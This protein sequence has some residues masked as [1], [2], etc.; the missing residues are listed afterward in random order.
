MKVADID[1]ARLALLNAG[2]TETRTLT[3][4]F[5]V[6]FLALLK[7]AFPEIGEA[8]ADR[9]EAARGEGISRRMVLLGQIMAERFADDGA[10]ALVAHPSDTVR[11]WACFLVGA[12]SD[13]S[14]AWRLEAVRPFA[15]DPHFGV[16]EWAW[17]AVR[18]HIAKDL[19]AAVALL[20]GWTASPSDRLRRFASEATRPRGV[21]CAHISVLK[22]TPDLG[23]PI[24]EPLRADP[25]GYVQDSVGNWLNDAAKSAPDWVRA[26]CEDWA[27]EDPSPA[28]RR[29]CKRAMRSMKPKPASA[30]KSRRGSA[31]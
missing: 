19:D 21:W 14:L 30:P 8:A 27:K 20:S 1:P 15:D 29:I 9:V 12:L 23:L 17:L 25:S 10:D 4:C 16:R 3:E 22:E 6:D 28:T 2:E 24:L 18:P 31:A 26:L 5:A 13:R 11:G 7:S